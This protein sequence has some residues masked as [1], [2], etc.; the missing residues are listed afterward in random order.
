MKMIAEYQPLIHSNIAEIINSLSDSDSTIH[1]KIITNLSNLSQ[2]G[3]FNRF[4]VLAL[5]T[6]NIVK[7]QPLIGPAIPMI[8]DLLED[9]NW[10]VSVACLKF[11]R[12]F[13]AQGKTVS[14]TLLGPLS[15]DSLA[16]FQHLIVPAISGIVNLLKDNN[17][18]VRLA[19]MHAL[20]TFSVYGKT[21][22]LSGLFCL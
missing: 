5:L 9:S 6:T 7:F 21:V 16:E 13:S 14:V 22:N 15:Y 20:L 19:S 8:V 11:L 10:D 12:T 4:L 2:Q 3:K 1:S 18:T 17:E